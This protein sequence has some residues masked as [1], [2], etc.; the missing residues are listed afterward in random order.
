M[1]VQNRDLLLYF[2]DC[3]HC[4]LLMQALDRVEFSIE[5]DVEV[6]VINFD[7]VCMF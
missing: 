4:L 7:N 2:D 1:H 6:R 5:Y 3:C